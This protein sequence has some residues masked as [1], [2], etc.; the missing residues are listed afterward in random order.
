[1]GIH[2]ETSDETCHYVWEQTQHNPQKARVIAM[3]SMGKDSIAMYLQLRRF[4]RREEIVPLHMVTLPG[5]DGRGTLTFV[6]ANI[7]YLEKAFG[8]KIYRLPHPA[9]YGQLS[10]HTLQP[11]ERNPM[12]E[13]MLRRKQI[14]DFQSDSHA[15]FKLFNHHVVNYCGFENVWFATGVRRNDSIQ[16]RTTLKAHGVAFPDTRQFYPIWDFDI[17]RLVQ[18]LIDCGVKL[19][20]DYVLFGR[21]FENLTE[22]VVENLR[23]YYP[24]DYETA[25]AWYPMLPLLPL[26]RR[27]RQL[28]KE[29]MHHNV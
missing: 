12:L 11:P 5:R 23:A 4:F 28:L 18:T 1:M 2:F 16:R 6:E 29:G 8:Q 24:E 17:K 3:L 22:T 7:A 13:L 21:S 14:G 25:K 19:P 10:Q 9:F 26:R 15:M 20:D 27:Y